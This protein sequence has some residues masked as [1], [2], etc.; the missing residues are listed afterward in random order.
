MN[1]ESITKS[2]TDAIYLLVRQLAEAK[3]ENKRLAAENTQLLALTEVLSADLLRTPRGS[4]SE[5]EKYYE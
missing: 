4:R 3:T 1:D 5:Q 2:K